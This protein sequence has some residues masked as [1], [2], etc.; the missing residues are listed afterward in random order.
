MNAQIIT[1]AL[2]GRHRF[3]KSTVPAIR[4]LEGLGVEGDAHSGATV[5]HRSRWKKTPE[6]PNLRQ[7]HL[8]CR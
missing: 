6:A 2:D 5:K 4:L 3:T 7:V 8:I 1:V